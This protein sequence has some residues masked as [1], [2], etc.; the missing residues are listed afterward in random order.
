[1]MPGPAYAGALAGALPPPRV[2]LDDGSARALAL[3]RFLGPATAA[4]EA[5]LRRAVEPVLDVGCGPGRHIRALARSGVSAVGVDMSA[6]AVRI[7]RE[8]GA[9]VVHGSVFGDVPGAGAWRSAL[10]LDGNVGIGGDPR[11][12]LHRVAALLRDDG[13]ILV[14][15][16]PPGTAT[17]RVRARLETPADASG[18]FAWAVVGADGVGAVARAA[19]LRPAGAFAAGGRWFAELRCA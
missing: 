13:R 1:M 19:G 14:E 9:T 16:A 6:A 10:L 18:W 11:R 2:R 12:L 4:D 3:G 7:A 17:R 15:T 5:V 8:R